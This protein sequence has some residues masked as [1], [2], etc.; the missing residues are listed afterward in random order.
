MTLLDTFVSIFKSDTGELEKG[1]KSAQKSTSDLVD[2]LK[3]AEHQSKTT[4]DKVAMFARGAAAF[5]ATAMSVS[6]IYGEVTKQADTINMMRQTSEE[7]GVAIDDLDAFRRTMEDNN[8]TAEAAEAAL[9]SVFQA[10]GNAAQDAEG[11]HGK[12]FDKLGVSVRDANGEVKNSIDLM[13]ELADISKDM[14]ASDFKMLGISDRRVIEQMRKGRMELENTIRSHKESGGVTKESA[15]MAKRYADATSE[16]SRAFEN[17]ARVLMAAFLPAITWATEK[18]TSLV[19]WM[20]ENKYF[21]AGFFGT[22]AMVLGTMYVPAM[23]KAAGVTLAATW[24]I[25]AIAAAIGLAAAAIALIVDDIWNWIDGND[26][27]IGQLIEKFPVIGSIIKGAIEIFRD[28]G[29]AVIGIFGAIRDEFVRLIEFLMSGFD[30]I[31]N[32]AKTVV[33]ALRGGHMSGAE[34]VLGMAGAHPMNSTTSQSIANTAVSNR[35]GD[36][37]VTIGEVKIETQ[38]TDAKGIAKDTRSELREQLQALNAETATGIA[39]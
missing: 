20:R 32:A 3:K 5:L 21:V 8:A 28:L 26:S 14:S 9:V 30:R 37:N 4:T 13:Y 34:A 12:I 22:I 27:L 19:N 10:A 17:G 36:S 15:E 18:V 35:G 2:Q 6:K 29:G 11:R 39:R 38:A 16:L 33:G 23:M 7:I 31:K 24:P 25:I 1:Y